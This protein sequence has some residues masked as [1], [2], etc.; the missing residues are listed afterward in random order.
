MTKENLGQFFLSHSQ[1]IRNA[2]HN[3]FRLEMPNPP[4]CRGLHTLA[5]VTRQCPP[6]AYLLP[7]QRK[8]LRILSMA[9]RVHCGTSIAIASIPVRTYW[10]CTLLQ[11]LV[12]KSAFQPGS[13]SAILCPVHNWL[14]LLL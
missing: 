8:P 10:T 1:R 7:L 6:L 5:Q 4:R 14:S 9:L 13:W 11:A 12:I 2:Q 3:S